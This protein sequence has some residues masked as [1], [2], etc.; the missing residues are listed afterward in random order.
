MITYRFRVGYVRGA[1]QIGG[2]LGGNVTA[3]VVTVLTGPVIGSDKDG[4]VLLANVPKK[5]GV[6]IVNDKTYIV[7]MDIRISK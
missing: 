3:A 5:N 6:N 2:L 4:H 7:Y 1:S